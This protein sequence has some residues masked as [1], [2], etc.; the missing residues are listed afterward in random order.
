MLH[1]FS[2]RLFFP[3]AALSGVAMGLFF[4]WRV[5]VGPWHGPR[6]HLNL[7]LAWMPYLMALLATLA[8]QRMGQQSWLF[9]GC[10]LL[11]LIFF[12]NAPY[13]ITD[14]LY[15]PS[16]QTHLWYSIIL[17]TAF[18]LCGLMLAAISL[19][20]IQIVV[21][22]RAGRTA[23][24]LLCST[25]LLLSGVGVYLG[26]FLR[27]NSWD[28]FTHPSQVWSDATQAIQ[29]HPNHAGL[30][31]FS[32]LFSLLLGAIYYTIVY[33]RRAEWSREEQAIWGHS[34]RDTSPLR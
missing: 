9:R 17:L 26:R 5:V 2:S 24:Y 23:G 18:T 30:I 3:L 20:L 14:W 32:F 34:R 22:R 29:Q 33:L 6:L 25:A 21:T 8:H 4:L 7:F 12:P 16:W 13:L 15:L 31:G 27:L 28:L 1:W 19:H 11:W 10:V